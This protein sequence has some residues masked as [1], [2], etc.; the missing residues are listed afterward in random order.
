MSLDE[1]GLNILKL[2]VNN[3][4][5]SGSQLEKE[6]GLSRKQLSYS[7]AKINFYLKEN[8]FEEIGRMRTGKFIIP[9][10]VINSYKTN[11]FTFDEG[12]YVFIEKERLYLIALILLQHKEELSINHFTSILRISKNTVLNDLKKLQTVIFTGIR[13]EAMV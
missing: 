1:R 9:H 5:I 7:L 3:P 2:L 13:F 4:T 8:G 11:Q 10:N 6:A 12:A